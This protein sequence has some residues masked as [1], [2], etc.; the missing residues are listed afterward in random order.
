M[1]E[2]SCAQ[3][4][5]SRYGRQRYPG[6]GPSALGALWFPFLF[7][8]RIPHHPQQY[9]KEKKRQFSWF[10]KRGELSRMSILSYLKILYHVL[11]LSTK[12]VIQ[13]CIKVSHSQKAFHLWFEKSDTLSWLHAWGEGYCSFWNKRL[14]ALAL[15]LW[16]TK[17]SPISLHCTPGTKW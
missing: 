16:M 15:G 13:S 1:E 14:R 8:P 3:G 7:I 11:A 4:R 5:L 6:S 12:L 2:T 17:E 10:Y 9:W